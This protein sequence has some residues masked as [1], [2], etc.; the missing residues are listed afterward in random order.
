MS[1][2]ILH[3]AENSWIKPWKHQW[4]LLILPKRL[5]AFLKMLSASLVTLQVIYNNKGKI[6]FWAIP[7]SFLANVCLFVNLL[8][9]NI[10]DLLILIWRANVGSII[11]QVT[12]L[13]IFQSTKRFIGNFCDM[14]RSCAFVQHAKY[15]NKIKDLVWKFYIVHKSKNIIVFRILW[16]IS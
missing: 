5:A 2:D 15:S 16:N 3:C 7:L 9:W 13:Q 14:I 10:F 4:R 6:G 12:F 8:P 11:T 1:T